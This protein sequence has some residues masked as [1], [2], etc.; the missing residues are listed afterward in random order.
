MNIMKYTR[1]SC[2]IIST[3]VGDESLNEIGIDWA[4]EEREVLICPIGIPRARQRSPMRFTA[5]R[6][7]FCNIFN[8]G[9]SFVNI[10]LKTY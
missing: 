8:H 7:T 9:I 3:S 1:D 6:E 2:M 4:E 10:V 5:P